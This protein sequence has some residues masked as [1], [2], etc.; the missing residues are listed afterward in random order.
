MLRA[1][2]S[3]IAIGIA[4]VVSLNYWGPFRWAAEFQISQFGT[5]RGDVS[6]FIVLLL[7]VLP[8]AALGH[9]LDILAGPDRR[10]QMLA[11]IYPLARLVYRADLMLSPLRKHR[12]LGMLAIGGLLIIA[13]A[14]WKLQIEYAATV[15]MTT[16]HV[17]DVLNGKYAAAGYVRL[18]HVEVLPQLAYTFRENKRV[19][20]AQTS[21]E[22]A[23]FP[24]IEQ[25]QQHD[26]WP[27]ALFAAM[28][29]AERGAV[30]SSEIV[31]ELVRH[32]LPGP[33]RDRVVELPKEHFVIH[34]RQPHSDPWGAMAIMLIG[35]LAL[36]VGVL[37][38]AIAMVVGP[39]R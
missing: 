20:G 38:G 17:A 39:R 13:G 28:S 9:W 12:W 11:L 3:L 1:I 34:V 29:T 6:F 30:P 18:T 33:I 25:G 36:T 37:W 14:G 10:A 26:H 35:G 15:P 22:T 2:F 21:I 32:G 19:L 7:S 16:V 8:A 23:F 31:G 5:Y 24:L 27:I 4:A